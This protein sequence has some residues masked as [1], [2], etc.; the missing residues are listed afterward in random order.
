MSTCLT[1]HP[2][3][4]Y[5]ESLVRAASVACSA[6]IDSPS[7]LLNILI[8]A[9]DDLALQSHWSQGR[10]K[11]V[12]CRHR[13]L[14]PRRLPADPNGPAGVLIELLILERG[15]LRSDESTTIVLEV[16]WCVQVSSTTTSGA[17]APA[18]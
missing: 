9:R 11:K 17:E 16:T 14:S 18:L 2:P 3:P 10:A 1:P 15:H 4:G 6:S 13:I 12:R 7:A 5:A 8:L